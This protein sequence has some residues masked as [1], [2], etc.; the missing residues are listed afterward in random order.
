MYKKEE[1][2][3]NE[4]EIIQSKISK[5]KKIAIAIAAITL[6]LVVS[7]TLLV[8][9]LKYDMFNN[10]DYK[11]DANIN[12]NIYQAN[13]FSDKKTIT[14]QF[15]LPDGVAQKKVFIVDTNF[16]VF[17]T[18]KEKNK[19]TA[20]L[21]ILNAQAT[22]D[23]KIKDLPHINLFDEKEVKELY[24]NPD[25]AKYPLAVFTFDDEGKI[26]EIKL[27]N[28]LDEYH[29]ETIVELIEKVIPKLSGNKNEDMSKGL[30]VKTTQS[31][32]KRTIVQIGG[33][34][35]T[36]PPLALIIFPFS[37]LKRIVRT[38]IEDNQVKKVDTTSDI[39]IQVEPEEG[40]IIFGPKDLKYDMKSEIIA[41]EE[42]Y[43]EK[44]YADLAKK[45]SDK[46][47]LVKY[48]DLINS[49]VAQKEEEKEVEETKPL[50]NLANFAITASRD[51][52]IA[53][54]TVLGQTV[55][56]KYSVKVTSSTA[57]NKLVITS[58]LG[59]FEFG[60]TGCTAKISNSRNY[61]WNIFTIPV[62]GT[63]GLV[64]IKCYAKGY[65]S[66]GF[67]VESGSG[68]GTKY[69]ASISG[70]LK[71]GASVKAGA[72]MIASLTAYAEGTI[73]DASGKAIVSKGS[74][75]KGSGF[76][77]S[78]GKLVAGVKGKALFGLI[79]TD[80]YSCTLYSGWKVV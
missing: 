70:G 33:P 55:S 2:L 24:A 60:N 50:R 4:P 26:L 76:S 43:N 16:A 52:P 51:F 10:G 75:A 77:I 58:G 35:K 61:D 49:I 62:P 3:I 56:I 30:E 38:E 18:D 46:F 80:I 5:R 20:S 47:T 13:Y 25:G 67:G 68:T 31:N 28:N 40:Q 63:A 7:I 19:N 12:R 14:A 41:N 34:I 36:P 71:L 79:N 74:V 6:I 22:E 69:Y 32:N 42:K 17:I 29:A 27:P 53:S 57:S 44:E 65:L 48:E 64:S 78:M 45:I 54:F 21:V 72:D 9:H 1:T 11:I 39:H 73:F 15:T 37:L 8:G 23:G 59:T 66:W